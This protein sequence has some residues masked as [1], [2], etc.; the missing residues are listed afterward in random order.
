MNEDLYIVCNILTSD[1]S[2]DP[3]YGGSRSDYF[4]VHYDGIPLRIPPGE[5]RVLPFHLA[6]HFA[7]HLTDHILISQ[8]KMSHDIVQREILHSQIILK[9]ADESDRAY[10]TV[11]AGEQ[12]SGSTAPADSFSSELPD[13]SGE[14]T[15][16]PNSQEGAEARGDKSSASGGQPDVPTR[17]V[18]DRN[19]K[20][21]ITNST[22]KK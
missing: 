5:T 19:H 1:D 14:G 13:S 10:E 2:I 16:L 7:K 17:T 22:R 6:E 8:G 15:D 9:K 11:T 21:R 18:T 4:E 12:E 3:E 20:G